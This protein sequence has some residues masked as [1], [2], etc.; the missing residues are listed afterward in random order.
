MEDATDL[1]DI[2]KEV[3]DEEADEE[4]DDAPQTESQVGDRVL[5]KE[6]ESAK[7]TQMIGVQ[8][9]KDFDVRAFTS[10]QSRKKFAQLLMAVWQFSKL[11]AI[12]FLFCKVYFLL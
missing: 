10:R 12:S 8:L 5:D 1:E 7:P 4:D 9:L 2:S 3:E 11:L 6:V